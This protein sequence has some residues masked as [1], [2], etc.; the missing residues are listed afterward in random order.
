MLRLLST[1]FFCL[2]FFAGYAQFGTVGI[3]GTATPSGWDASTPMVQDDTDPNVWTLAI[4]LVDG[5][6]KF[7][8]DDDW[9]VNWGD[10]GFPFGT[11]VQNGPNIQV[12]AGDY[13]ITFNSETG[14]YFFDY[15][16]DIGIIGSATPFGWDREVFMFRDAE[17]DNKYFVTLDLVQ[18]AAK[19]RADGDWA[20]N[21]G[22]ADFPSGIGEQNGPDIPVPQA[23]RYSI[24]FDKS[25]GEYNF[26]AEIDFAT[27]GII[28]SAT[29]GGWDEE[30]PLTRDSGNPDVWRATVT[31]TEG[32]AKFRA[33][34]SWAVNWGGTDFPAGVAVLNGDN[35]PVPE[36]GDY[37]VTFNTNTLDYSFLLIGD[38][39]TVG[40][41]GDATPGGW[42]A[43]TPMEQ[44]PNDKS[45][46]RL[47]VELNTGEA[48]FRADGD[49]AVNWGGGTFPAG[50]AEQDG[51]N[52]PVIGGEY[53]VTF[54][55]T[56]GD[57]S[58][59]EVF[60]YRAVSIV[61]VSGP[62]NVW[63]DPAD[64]GA[65]DWFLEKGVEDPHEWTAPSVQLRNFADDADGGIK[66]RADTAWAVNWGAADFPMGVG[67]QDGPNIQPVAGTYSVVF[68]SLSGEYAF[69]PEVSSREELLSPSAVK[70]FPNP[71]STTVTVSLDTDKL[72]NNI[73]VLIYDL[74]GRQVMSQRYDLNANLE[75]N[76]A[77][78]Q[79]GSYLLSIT[80]GKYLIG[81]QLLIAR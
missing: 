63:P 67:T 70:L 27:I 36:A 12:I 8:A 53:R 23:G 45:V 37:I 62:F 78:L 46:W 69:G 4:T 72:G 51:P 55:S 15:A 59:E 21:W 44:D 56:T 57:Y 75:L 68:N 18:G 74:S 7:R 38:Y 80:D 16:S 31:L 52:I 3:I 10:T 61:G 26:E 39:E 34:T 11:G 42:D 73:N 19:F 71:A 25:T 47:R 54:N 20:V 41:I 9:A 22:A 48:K 29:P 28:G 24:T 65:T 17:D 43:D 79:A 1:T 60:E 35:I 13:E 40:I 14:E 33:D 32:E 77:K 76:V 58:F 5:E 64:M 49:W 30:T 6:A 66:F 81:K 50:V 2:L